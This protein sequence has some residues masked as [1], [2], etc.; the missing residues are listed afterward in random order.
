M[1]R[2]DFE[3][4][5]RFFLE[6]PSSSHPNNWLFDEALL[7]TGSNRRIPKKGQILSGRSDTFHWLRKS[8]APPRV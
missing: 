1:N 5:G 7:Q 8:R 4:F 6:T 3:S 2:V